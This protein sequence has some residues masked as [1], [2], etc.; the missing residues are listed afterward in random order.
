M[1]VPAFRAAA[2]ALIVLGPVPALAQDKL[3][4]V[5]YDPTR[6]FYQEFNKAFADQWQQQTGEEVTIQM[7]H[8]GAGKQARAVIDDC[9]GRGV[10]PVLVG[11]SALYTRAV[12][13]R[14]LLRRLACAGQHGAEEHEGDALDSDSR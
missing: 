1:N 3:L 13:D 5:S 8:G 9:R 6:E 2:L 10:V 7:S 11:G 4:N 12:L 14:V